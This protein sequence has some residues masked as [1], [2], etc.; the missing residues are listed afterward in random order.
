MKYPHL[1]LCAA[2][3][4]CS[5]YDDG[6][7]SRRRD[8]ARAQSMESPADEAGSQSSEPPEAGSAGDAAGS[9]GN[10][11]A[12][13][14][15]AGG[16]QQSAGGS[17]GSSSS[18]SPERPAVNNCGNGK[19]DAGE[20]CDTAIAAGKPGSCPTSCTL[21]DPCQ[22]VTLQGSGC[23]AEC[24]F[25]PRAC[26]DADKCCPAGCSQQNDDDCA[27]TCGDSILQSDRG[28]TC[29]NGPNAPA[30]ARCPT[31]AD[32]EDGDSCT[33]GTLEGSAATCNAVCKQIPITAR[34][35]DDGCCPAGANALVDDDCQPACGNGV[36]EG[37]EACDGSTGCD[38]GCRLTLSSSQIQCMD[39]LADNACEQCECQHCSA[40]MLRCGD[41]GNT[42]RDAACTAVED[43]ATKYDCSGED[44]YCGLSNILF[45]TVVATGPCRSVIERAADTFNAYVIQADYLD[46][47]T[48]LGRAKELGECRRKNCSKVCP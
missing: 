3:A 20:R 31:E 46:D 26:V 44:C 2:L 33:V 28:E 39:E 18:A 43:C 36:K 35:G 17:S 23:A 34:H 16:Q 32:C 12:A 22:T 13:I 30:S 5:V 11:S 15:G 27:P 47:N 8:E 10:G 1:W 38:T 6:L 7:V 42:K 4:A 9:G 37:S 25:T 40:Q 14:G 19:L 45:C 41:S 48:A 24:K 21:T 29:D